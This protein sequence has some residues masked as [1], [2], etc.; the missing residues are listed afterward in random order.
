MIVGV[1]VRV[2]AVD[3]GSIG[4]PSKFAWASLD[5]P[6][7]RN[8]AAGDDPETAVCDLLACLEK[9]QSAVLLLESPMSVPVPPAQEGRWRVLGKARDGEGNRP[10]SAGA[11]A[12]VLA[13]GLV[14]GAWMLGR[15][16]AAM[17]RLTVTTHAD[18]WQRDGAQLLLA[19]AFVS[20][21]GK[22]VPLPASQ[23]AADAVAAGLALVE[24]L[25]TDD[26]LISDV[27]CFPQHAFNL[28]AA[29]AMWAGLRVDP[30]E[31]RQ[32]VLV[33]HAKPNLGTDPPHS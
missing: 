11:G 1:V 20:G 33:I 17:P 30:G 32:D 31:L 10:W 25:D 26:G 14:Q 4:P 3:V 6:G 24:R 5:V 12:G 21:D 19:E 16:A 8:A 23:H 18:L 15:L 2:V 9:G 22:P 27:R 7:Q 28:L 13:T 29:T